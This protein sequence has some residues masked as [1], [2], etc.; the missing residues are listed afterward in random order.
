MFNDVHNVS[1]NKLRKVSLN[2]M[3]F[4]N[5][6]DFIISGEVYDTKYII[7]I[8]ELEAP[9]VSDVPLFVSWPELP[10]S[11][12]NNMEIEAIVKQNETPDAP[13]L[14]N[15]N[16]EYGD[17][18]ADLHLPSNSI[19]EWTFVDPL[20][21]NVGEVGSNAF[22]VK[23]IPND[24]I[25][26]KELI[27]EV[28]VIVAK[29]EIEI[30][31]SE[32]TFIYTGEDITLPYSLSI[33]DND[34]NVICNNTT[35][36]D[37]GEYLY[38]IQIDD[39]RYE[40]SVNGTWEIIPA[41]VVINIPD[42]TI[43]YDKINELTVPEY[44][45]SG[46]ADEQLSDLNIKVST[47]AN[48]TNVGQY[49][50]VVTYA[51]SPNYKVEVVGGNINVTKAPSTPADPILDEMSYGDIFTNSNI[52][53]VNSGKWQLINT[54]GIYLDEVGDYK[55]K[56]EFIPTDFINYETVIK[57]FIVNVN[58]RKVEFMVNN[59]FTY[60]GKEQE[61]TY[62]FKN[63]IDGDADP[64][65]NI[66]GE[67]K[68][69]NVTTN[70]NIKLVVDTPYYYGEYT[71]TF[72]INKKKVEL[73]GE[74][75]NIDYSENLVAPICKV[76][77]EGV[78][79]GET[80]EY[81]VNKPN[82]SDAREYIYEILVEEE[83]YPNYDILITNG[84]LIVNKIEYNLAISFYPN[85]ELIY[86]DELI[87]DKF[88][89]G[90]PYGKFNLISKGSI[91]NV[92]EIEI[93]FEFVPLNSNYLPT[94]VTN[95]YVVGKKKVD[96]IVDDDTTKYIYDGNSHTVLGDINKEDLVN[97]NDEYKIVSDKSFNN[98]G[99]H[100]VILTI[101]SDKYEGQKEVNLTIS[102]KEIE[103]ILP[104]KEIKFNDNVPSI[105]LDELT[106][107]ADVKDDLEI[108]ITLPTNIVKIGDYY[109]KAISNNENYKVTF[110]GGKLTVLPGEYKEDLIC[111]SI[112]NPIYGTSYN[113]LEFS[114]GSTGGN[115]SIKD[116]ELNKSVSVG[117]NSIVF[118][119]DPVDENYLSK[120]VEANFTS[121]AK[122][123]EIIVNVKTFDYNPNK[124]LNIL[125][126]NIKFNGLVEDDLDP[127]VVFEV[128]DNKVLLNA[129]EYEVKFIVDSDKYK[130]QIVETIIINKI[131][132]TFD[133]P[134][135]SG[136]YNE[137]LNT[138]KLPSNFKFVNAEEI[139]NSRPYKT[140]LVFI[141]D[142][143]TNYNI[144]EFEIEINVDKANFIININDNYTFV[145]SSTTTTE[146]E[147]IVSNISHPEDAKYEITYNNGESDIDNIN[148]AGSYSAIITYSETANYNLSTKTIIIIV[149]NVPEVL[150][151]T[152]GQMLYDLVLPSDENGH[153]EF[154]SENIQLLHV[155]GNNLYAD[156]EIKYI[157]NNGEVAQ[158]TTIS[159]NLAKKK[160]SIVAEDLN[161]TYDGKEHTIEFIIDGTILVDG[162]YENI[163]DSINGN[164]VKTN[165]CSEN[166]RL[167][168]DNIYYEADAVDVSLTIT[169]KEL[170][171]DIADVTIYYGNEL[172]KL[173]F[174]NLDLIGEDVVN[175]T[176][177]TNYTSTSNVGG[178]YKYYNFKSDNSNYIIK[179]NDNNEVIINLLQATPNLGDIKVNDVVT[180]GDKVNSILDK[181]T[182]NN[183][184]D[185]KFVINA[186]VDSIVNSTKF[187]ISLTF[188]P[189]DTTNYTN[190]E[191]KIIIDAAKKELT[192]NLDEEETTFTY[193]KTEKPTKTYSV[194]G[195]IDSL[196]KYEVD[197]KILSKTYNYNTLMNAD[198]YT[199][200]YTINSE[201]Y[202][203]ETSYEVVINPKE[204]RVI[205]DNIKLRYDPNLKDSDILDYE[206]KF[207][208]DSKTGK[209]DII[210]GDNAN[211]IIKK[212]TAEFVLNYYKE[213]PKIA[214]TDYIHNAYNVSFDN[215]NYIVKYSTSYGA[216]NKNGISLYVTAGDYEECVREITNLPGIDNLNELVYGESLRGDIKFIGGDQDGVW[217][218]SD[219]DD[220]I[221]DVNLEVIFVPNIA[222]GLYNEV[223]GKHISFEFA[224][225]NKA[226]LYL[227][228]TKLIF[229][230]TAEEQ[231]I[232]YDVSG[233]VQIG[234]IE[235]LGIK[236]YDKIDTK[237]SS[238]NYKINITGDIGH[239][240][241]GEY[242]IEFG[243]DSKYYRLAE[244][245]RPTM[246]ITEADVIISVDGHVTNPDLSQYE[247]SAYW[248]KAN[249]NSNN[250][251]EMSISSSVTNLEF[252]VTL[253]DNTPETI[254]GNGIVK[255]KT[256][257]KH[258][259]V[260]SS[261]GN[262][263]VKPF[264]YTYDVTLYAAEVSTSTNFKD[265]E[266]GYGYGSL[267]E[268]IEASA[269]LAASNDKIYIYVY[270]DAVIDKDVTIPKNVE[271]YL[272]HAGG[273]TKYIN[274]N[275]ESGDKTNEALSD[276]NP[277]I[278]LDNP[279]LYLN[280]TILDGITV[281]LNGSITIGADRGR[282][283]NGV[284][285]GE[286][287]S[288]YSQITLNGQLIV[289]GTLMSFGKIIDSGNIVANNNAKV[290]ELFVLTAWR[291][292]T[293][294]AGLYGDGLDELN[295]VVPFDQYKMHNIEVPVKIN[296]GAA[297]YGLAAI[298]TDSYIS[299]WNTC[300]YPLIGKNAII[301]PLDSNSYIYKKYNIETN[302]TNIEIYGNV[303]DNAGKLSGVPLVGE[304][305]T[306]HI[307]F[308][309]S[310][311]VN[312]I[313]KSNS[314]F[315]MYFKYKMLPGSEII[316]EEN[317]TLNIKENAK[318]IVYKDYID[319]RG[320][321]TAY[322]NDKGE[323]KL[324]VNGTLNVYGYFAGIAQ[325]ENINAILNLSSAQSLEIVTLEGKGT[326]ISGEHTML[327]YQHLY[328]YNVDA[329]EI[330]ITWATPV[331]N[332]PGEAPSEL[333]E[334]KL[335]K[336]EYHW[337]G[338]A[339]TK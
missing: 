308:G 207:Y 328:A 311:N 27:D 276:V 153:W 191:E 316:I 254:I 12:D 35:K 51:E 32:T 239:T 125:D 330:K 217:R 269:T 267:V 39:P 156:T 131:D 290:Y 294:A 244:N 300:E 116:E 141:P 120:E 86:G 257:G 4:N 136:V 324:I 52:S 314:T 303:R 249:V 25:K 43:T 24:P 58:R 102:A 162:K 49:K 91:N 73:I 130:G 72:V 66:T 274:Y 68:G 304:I 129:D 234:G 232:E 139:I 203:G 13:M 197:I 183:S 84:K 286:I 298:K 309:I 90:D 312:I 282:S 284:V 2:N 233:F 171:K 339:W 48:I 40:G 323:P 45:I 196:P 118:I 23:F 104:N 221:T 301:E 150:N 173:D 189:T 318:L 113:D 117:S 94:K 178:E 20:T 148:T 54:D 146:F 219:V 299:Q 250:E 126:F 279:N 98:V 62:E 246:I 123:I 271:L 55:V 264:E 259:I 44:N 228:F 265:Q 8:E 33:E 262:E 115:W 251:Y 87:Q 245:Y 334:Y 76:T 331:N 277:N 166:V 241:V 77:T 164:I 159:I 177:E 21:T 80:I 237:D 236:W 138:V 95:T 227:E 78:V 242:I 133:M 47:P 169:P 325:S 107:P 329:S 258:S 190:K 119:F 112:T 134:S 89:G 154:V 194:T 31:I 263:Q 14:N 88:I 229:D 295:N 247:I 287:S 37:V 292:G 82:V 289:N 216:D 38:I 135:L 99:E 9:E 93:E 144:V 188:I 143:Q 145:A 310:Y 272:V 296:Y 179:V 170:V 155:P 336:A 65:V 238:G 206:P 266:K 225:E 168:L 30:I 307:F 97:S 293:N 85:A 270:N 226:V 64:S 127:E 174:S 185:G 75:I 283:S 230:Y 46:L 5:Q 7:N 204:A 181:L 256:A 16:A 175:I 57:E 108:I 11:I 315:D 161:V 165:V 128:N 337:N 157:L 243:I 213:N 114:G 195:L 17:T 167:T 278:Q 59:V 201:Y 158:T 109:Y 332:E 67:Y 101:E 322:P 261:E 142:D 83:N 202:I 209:T 92:G 184:I 69:I 63:V 199:I 111:P 223:G 255:I 34:I 122:N 319:K 248:D 132:P 252:S 297:Y 19:G 192:I 29:K 81:I 321:V 105:E 260:V 163:D 200:T 152:Y 160:V 74:T 280:V 79:L 149:T 240:E 218:V 1:L 96:I 42:V 61:L 273:Y 70:Q 205:Y 327:A 291:G 106:I 71:T 222:E 212:P 208:V 281:T 6:V 186:E 60:N 176:Y 187:E 103:V 313:I 151:A 147:K 172:P 180:I 193:D 198:T 53:S 320:G 220:L 288:S 124:E 50:F 275:P 211:I 182:Y 253:D 224:E 305:S 333:D 110:I 302:E 326:G 215:S 100:K 268:A 231:H 285:Q 18:L 56:L 210:D 121:Q 317:A 22:A 338:T 28:N 140:K 26:Y 137:K 10:T 15:I 3:L 335:E 36:K 41:D 235:S 214:S 306:E